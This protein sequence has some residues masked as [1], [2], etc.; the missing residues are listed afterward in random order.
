MND[1]VRQD[2]DLGE[3]IWSV[4]EAIADLSTYYTLS[5]GDLI[6]TG[7]PAGVGALT[8]GDIVTG[9]VDG[10]GEIAISIIQSA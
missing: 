4:P 5:P 9:G 6:F 7:T 10:V 3:L 1:E 2:G 8:V